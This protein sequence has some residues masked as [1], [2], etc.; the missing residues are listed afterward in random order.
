[1]NNPEVAKKCFNDGYCCS[2]A[3]LSTYAE[4]Y[5]LNRELSLKIAEVFAAGIA[6]RGEICGAVTGAYMVIGLSNGRTKAD[7][8][9]SKEK[10]LRLVKEFN[11][12]FIEKHN[13]IKCSDLLGIKI[14]NP[15]NLNK[16]KELNLF[17]TLCPKFIESS[18]EIVDI[19]L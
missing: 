16:A 17:K 2:Q 18:A 12:K 11:N 6:Y 1:M 10:S 8:L 15:E 4:R 9:Q 19:L 7:D 13:S 5:G 14:D 3:V